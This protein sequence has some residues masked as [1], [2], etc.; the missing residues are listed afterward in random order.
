MKDII[1]RNHNLDFNLL[2]EQKNSLYELIL[3]LNGGTAKEHYI[4]ILHLIEN[5]QETAVLSGFSENKV[6]KKKNK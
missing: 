5:I 4:G 3:S 6:F 1:L 2:A